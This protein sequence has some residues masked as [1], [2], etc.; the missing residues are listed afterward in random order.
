L[1]E[2]GALED[3]RSKSQK[4]AAQL[5]EAEE[6][7]ARLERQA[8]VLSGTSLGV[9]GLATKITNLKQQI[10]ILRKRADL[11]R[12]EITKAKESFRWAKK[13]LAESKKEAAR[14]EA[15]GPVRLAKE[16]ALK[17]I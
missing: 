5:R 7:V 2:K 1:P 12:A 8:E 9:K 17:S 15:L 4:E 14:E 3:L 11:F 10:T 13:D 16:E 6:E